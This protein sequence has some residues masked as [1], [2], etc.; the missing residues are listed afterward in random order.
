MRAPGCYKHLESWAW[1]FNDT[2][3]VSNLLLLQERYKNKQEESF[4]L[5]PV[6]E[7]VSEELH[8]LTRAMQGVDGAAET[9]HAKLKCPIKS[10]SQRLKKIVCCISLS[11]VFKVGDAQLEKDSKGNIWMQIREVCVCVYVW[12]GLSVNHSCKIK[13]NP[14]RP[15]EAD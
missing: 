9:P 6:V 13:P 15:G 3:Q 10:L 14:H 11:L 4:F 7:L 8:N 2:S 5:F 1:K 12:G